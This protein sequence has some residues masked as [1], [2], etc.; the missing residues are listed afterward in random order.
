[1]GKG[2]PLEC[3]YISQKIMFQGLMIHAF[4]EASLITEPIP[5]NALSYLCK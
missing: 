1:M 3:K 4:N 5:V 2:H